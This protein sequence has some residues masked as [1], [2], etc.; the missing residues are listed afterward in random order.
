LTY[1]T[2]ASPL[3]R[4]PK[5]PLVRPRSGRVPVPVA[6]AYSRARVCHAGLQSCAEE[7]TGRRRPDG[8]WRPRCRDADGKEHARHFAKKADGQRWLDEVTASVVTGMYVDPKAGRVSLSAFYAAWAARQVW[9]PGTQLAMGLAVRSATF[10]DVELRLLRRSHVESWVKQM[11]AA[12]LAPGTVHPRAERARRPA[13][14][15]ARPGHRHR[16]ERR[17]D[18]PR[19]RRREHAMSIPTPPQVGALLAVA[20]DRFATFIALCAFG[21]LRLGEAAALQVGDVDFLRRRMVVSRQVRRGPGGTAELRAPKHG[22]ER[23]VVVPDRLLTLIARHVE[24]HLAA[25]GLERWLFPTPA[26]TPHRLRLRRGHRAAGPR[27]GLGDHDAERLRT[28]VAGRGGPHPSRHGR[29][30]VRSTRR[31][32]GLSADR[33][34]LTS[35]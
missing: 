4:S 12:G 32:C 33:T 25:G 15:R 16:S 26:G 27:A 7:S 28:P 1:Y 3:S 20:D 5:S 13:R 24:R 21:G 10:K 23:T 6:A 34:T 9:A 35:V 22:S 30:D 31:F 18:T 17:G 8:T 11:T 2:Q 19:R 29:P 14:S